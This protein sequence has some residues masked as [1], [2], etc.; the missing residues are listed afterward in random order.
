MIRLFLSLVLL[1]PIVVNSQNYSIKGNFE[2]NKVYYFTIERESVYESPEGIEKG[3]NGQITVSEAVF[4]PFKNKIKCKWKYGETKLTGRDSIIYGSD[5]KMKAT[6][7][8]FKDLELE[9][10]IDPKS[11]ET[12]LLDYEK[13][14]ENIMTCFFS[15]AK[16]NGVQITD[17][18][19]M[20]VVAELGPSFKTSEELLSGY[21]AEL[22]LYLNVY[23]KHYQ[24]GSTTK[25]KRF[26]KNSIEQERIPVQGLI[27]VG[28]KIDNILTL[29][30]EL[31][32]STQDAK[33]I[34]K[35]SFQEVQK[36]KR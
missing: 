26:I 25:I 10:V 1:F 32:A 16:Q 7:N 20:V 34:L 6:L 23:F 13:S 3:E 31:S 14:K 35:V 29:H 18:M 30:S 36:I 28:D 24:K 11:G 12:T 17:E 15:L 2:T 5:P 9:V 8:V 19:R 22:M 27:S 33:R 4:M 21:G